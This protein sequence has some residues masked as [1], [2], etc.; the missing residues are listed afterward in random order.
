MSEEKAIMAREEF[1]GG[2]EDKIFTSID[3]STI[4][5]KI[6]TQNCLSDSDYNLDDMKERAFPIQHVLAHYVNIN[7][8]KG[9]VQAIRTV[10]VTSDGETISFTSDGVIASLKRIFGL[11]GEPPW[12][13]PLWMKAKEIRTRNGW[14]TINLVVVKSPEDA[15]GKTIDV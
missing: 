10:L 4:D 6:M 11:M 15:G 7:S 14:R 12:D 5:G 9:S 2:K 3:I 1:F 8:E 13:P